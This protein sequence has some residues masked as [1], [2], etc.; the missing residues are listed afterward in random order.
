MLQMATF[1]ETFAKLDE[2]M[3]KL[4][5][6][7]Y[8]DK[9]REEGKDLDVPPEEEQKRGRELIRDGDRNRSSA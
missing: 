6:K 1:R 5:E 7:R 8:E 2:S 4:A 9:L 3:K